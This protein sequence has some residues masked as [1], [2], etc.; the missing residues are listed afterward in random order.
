VSTGRQ[1]SNAWEG[2]NVR[3]GGRGYIIIVSCKQV[4]TNCFVCCMYAVCMH[5]HSQ[6]DTLVL[7]KDFY[8]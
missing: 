1:S 2:G 4:L 5:T 6:I 7:V 8:R 3:G